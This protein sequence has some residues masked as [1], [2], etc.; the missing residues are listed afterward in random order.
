LVDSLDTLLGEADFLSLHV[1]L[2]RK[3]RHMIDEK[4][5]ARMK[6]RCR[7]VNTLRGAAIEEAALVEALKAGV[8]TGA[9]L[10][11][12]DVEPLAADHAAL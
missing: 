9:A 12:F 11:V 5:L 2:S 6:P 8:V 7:I 1:P 10:D 4:A 3:T